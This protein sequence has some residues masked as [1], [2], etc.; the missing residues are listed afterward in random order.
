[1][2]Y[3]SSES[4]REDSNI[5]NGSDNHLIDVPPAS[6]EDI[7]T[8]PIL[9]RPMI[10][11]L[12]SCFL[13]YLV[14][15]TTGFDGSLMSSIYT[16]EDYLREFNLD[17]DSST[18]TGIIFSI[19]NIGQIVGALFCP[20]IDWKG[21]K[22]VI[23][24]G[25]LGVVVGAVI[26]AVSKNIGTL[27]AGRFILSFFT[28]LANTAAPLYVTEIAAP[29]ARARIAGCYN[30]L[31]YCGAII[32]A[33]TAYGANLHHSG[34]S[35][36][37]RLPLGI[38]AVCPGIVFIFGWFIPES[39]RWLVGVGR[40]DEARQVIVNYHCNGNMDHP[41]VD[42]EMAGME[43]SFEGK[44][45]QNSFRLLDPRPLFKNRNSYRSCLVI[46][47]A[48]FGQFSGNNCASYYLPTM[49][50]KIGMT[51]VTTN[52]LM[53][54][55]YSIVAWMASIVGAFAH[56][57][58]GRRK[59]LMFSTITAALA[60]T[61]LAIST[62]RYNAIPTKAASQSALAFIY[63]FGIFF[64]FAFTPVQVIYACEVASNPMRSRSM[65]IFNITAGIAQF[66]NQFA[67]PTAMKNISYW[68]Y[69]FYVFWDLFECVVIYFFFV[70]T[71]SRT[72][73]EMDEIFLAKN[74][75]KVSVG[76]YEDENDDSKKF[77]QYRNNAVTSISHIFSK[78]KV[79]EKVSEAV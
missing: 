19:Y 52:V 72:L 22:N 16:Q 45:L 34:S 58:I 60:L 67:T 31:W 27:L 26:T 4:V 57:R 71:K 37:F 70:E 64:S 47:I 41:L 12:A 17:A 33:F 32:A 42:F 43:A 53:N 51:S 23:I 68:F 79:E 35:L 30:T 2:S 40:L 44:S 76:N 20:F 28:T 49:L 66:I 69:V 5:K 7:E 46:I 50:T 63:L 15:T 6:L 77:L 18:S 36:S 73:E 14:A 13:I 59:M 9:S 62:A 8:Y 65:I 56:E 48:F 75:R 24:F 3:E 61:G 54:A 74:P 1:M 38:Q 11:L 25:C 55:V 39:P 10:P 21:R 78:S 29:K